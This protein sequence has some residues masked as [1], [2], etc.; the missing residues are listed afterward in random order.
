[1][2]GLEMPD[3]LPCLDV[4]TQDALGKQIVAESMAAVEVRAVVLV[5]R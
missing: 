4:E 5:G 2:H 3:A 1:M